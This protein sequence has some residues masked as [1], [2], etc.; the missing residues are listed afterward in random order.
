MPSLF[1]LCIA[2]WFTSL[3]TLAR[4][5]EPGLN[6]AL[7]IF[8]LHC[9]QVRPHSSVLR[10]WVHKGRNSTVR[11]LSIPLP[12]F[13][14]GRALSLF[15]LCIAHWFTSL[16]TLARYDE[17]GLNLALRIFILHCYQVRPHSSVLRCLVQMW[18]AAHQLIHNPNA[19]HHSFGDSRA[20][21]AL[22]G[23]RILRY[24]IP[25]TACTNQVHTR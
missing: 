3:S 22:D 6:L 12:Y 18:L 15:A 9:Y 7:R 8:I 20:R 14:L 21:H 2:H 16:S 1:A 4:Y 13:M 23:V 24:L 17:P 5:D 11:R 25:T 19:T 10:W